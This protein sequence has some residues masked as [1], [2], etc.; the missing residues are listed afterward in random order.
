MRQ[1][2]LMRQTAEQGAFVRAG[3]A[4][5]RIVAFGE[6]GAELGD[7]GSQALSLEEAEI[8]QHRLEIIEALNVPLMALLI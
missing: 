8:A 2:A 6:F 4:R 1:P 3:I 5:S 7:G